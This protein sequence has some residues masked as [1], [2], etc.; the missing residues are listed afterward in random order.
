MRKKNLLYLYFA[1]LI[2]CLMLLGSLYYSEVKHMVPCNLC[3]YQRIALFPLVILL[4]IALYKEDVESLPYSFAFPCFG[5]LI[6]GYQVLMQEFPSIGPMH[7][8]SADSLNSC[9]IKEPISLG[10]I[11]LPMLSCL[12]SFCIITLLML[13]YKNKSS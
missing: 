5:F 3:W 13:A 11:T 9:F 4:G 2:S 12:S 10:F 7:V 6:S 8:C 1:W